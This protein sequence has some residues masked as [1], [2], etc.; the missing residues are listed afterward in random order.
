MKLFTAW[1]SE[2][3]TLASCALISNIRPALPDH[4]EA[5]VYE[6]TPHPRFHVSPL[7]PEEVAR[8]IAQAL[9]SWVQGPRKVSVEATPPGLQE[10]RFTRVQV[11]CSG[12]SVQKIPIYEVNVVVEK[13]WFNLYR[14]WDENRLGLMAFESFKATIRLRAEDVQSRLADAK[15]LRDAQVQFTDEKIRVR[16]RYQGF[17]VGLTAHMVV[18]HS[19]YSRVVVVLDRITLAGIPLPGWLLGKASRQILWTY[20]IPDFPGRILIDRVTIQNGEILI[21]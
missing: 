12:C 10:G 18:D 14:L 11:T 2:I 3:T 21:S 15:G 9:Q 19:R 7:T 17:P 16:G 4:S 8:H 13:P 5:L 1:N 6:R 20:P